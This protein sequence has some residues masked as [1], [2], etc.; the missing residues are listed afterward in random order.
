MEEL[1]KWGEEKAR[2]REESLKKRQE[3]A[4]LMSEDNS[5]QEKIA[6][7]KERSRRMLKREILTLNVLNQINSSTNVTPANPDFI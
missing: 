6:A 3:I 5:L 1:R 7:L 2:L 4:R